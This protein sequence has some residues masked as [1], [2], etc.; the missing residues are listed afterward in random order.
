MSANSF[1]VGLTRDFLKPDGTPSFDTKALQVLEADSRIS[2]EFMKEN[3]T[4]V[5]ADQA[6]Q[7]DAIV[8]LTPRVTAATVARPDKRLSL[9]ARFGVGYDSV[10]VPALSKAGVALTITPD[11]VRRPVATIIL[12]FV[13]ALSHNL[14]IK[15]R[16]TKQGRWNE[17][18]NHM[19]T[20]LTG[21]VFGSIG[22]G[23]IGREVFKLLAPL[24]M[25][26]IACDPVA[27]KAEMAKDGI[28]LVDMDTLLKTA[29]FVSV[30]CPLNEKTKGLVNARAFGL[31]KKTAYLINTARGPVVDEKALIAALASKQIAGAA[32]DVFEV[33]P[34]PADNP[35]LKFDNVITT[36][37]ALCF[38]DECFRLIA[39]SAFR[40]TVAVAQGQ[41]PTST[42]VNR[43]VL[44][45]PAF[46][47]RLGEGKG[48]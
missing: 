18:T 23:N 5:T 35:L 46:R 32:I 6:A 7:Y 28:E 27:D 37:H 31:M 41:A 15:D 1:R 17:R 45:H 3:T 12:T 11:G 38:T 22:V 48:A 24:E 26:H 8:V 36:P 42:I 9:I 29:D 40:S 33:E 4:E 34:T 43:E 19:G 14:I 16:L 21:K 25:K 39:E 44:Q 20:G 47:A 30:S 13:L 2:Y 10:D